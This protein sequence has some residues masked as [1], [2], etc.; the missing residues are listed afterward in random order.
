MKRI[1]A[2]SAKELAHKYMGVVE[3]GKFAEAIEQLPDADRPTA[4]WEYG[5]NEE[6]Q[7]RWKCSVCG[8]ICHKNP[9]DK[10]YCSRCG[11]AMKMEA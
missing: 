3:Y 2:E 8:K 4:Y 7:A 6:K 9:Y 11:C 5:L 1:S 10:K